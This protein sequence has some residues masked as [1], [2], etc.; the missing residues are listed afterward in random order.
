MDKAEKI[1]E[2]EYHI[3]PGNPGP[4]FQKIELY[5]RAYM[6][7]KEFWEQVYGDAGAADCFK[8]D[9]FLRQDFIPVLTYKNEIVAM[10]LYTLFNTTNYAVRDHRYFAFYPE[11]FFSYLSD[12]QSPYA[13]SIEYLTVAPGW[14]KRNVGFSIGESLIGCSLNYLEPTNAQVAIAPARTDNKVHTMCYNFGFDCFEAGITKRNFS[15]DLVA[16]FKEKVQKNP[17]EKINQLIEHMWA[18]RQDHTG[19]IDQNKS[20]KVAA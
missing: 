15:V 3:L 8:P 5:H 19:R 12:K 10:H 7:W 13:M 2:T 14:R 6:M 9:D 17:S 20:L 18:H 16:G 4:G 1:F 11:N